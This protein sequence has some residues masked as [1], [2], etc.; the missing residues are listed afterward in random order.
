[1]NSTLHFP[2]SGAQPI[3]QK[4]IYKETAL[5]RTETS[6]WEVTWK[7][8]E[9][10]VKR[11][12]GLAEGPEA[13]IFT[14]GWEMR[15]WVAPGRL[16][17]EN[18]D[19]TIDANKNGKVAQHSFGSIPWLQDLTFA[20][21]PFIVSEEQELHFSV[22]NPV[23]LSKIDLIAKKQGIKEVVI[24]LGLTRASVVHLSLAGWKKYFW[25]AVGYFDPAGG[26]M[27][28]FESRAAP[29]I[30]RLVKELHRVEQW[31]LTPAN[32]SNKS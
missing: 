1:M 9:I 7:V 25:S 3:V 8:D 15:K 13:A 10:A 12:G 11:S 16:H 14:P 6:H 32:P 17:L 21:K 26:Y 20:L 5:D 30:P 24:P 23:D 2:T 19:G 22:V 4:F 29:G 31:D 18:R 27:L 28:R